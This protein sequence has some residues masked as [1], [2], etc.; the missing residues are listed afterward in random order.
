MLAFYEHLL[1]GVHKGPDPLTIQQ[2]IIWQMEVI[3]GSNVPDLLENRGLW[4]GEGIKTSWTKIAQIRG[5]QLN[6]IKNGAQLKLI[7]HP[8]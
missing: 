6:P 2:M 3:I 1:Q 8:T 5:V 7:S 4:V